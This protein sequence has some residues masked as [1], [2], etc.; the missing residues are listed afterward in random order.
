MLAAVGYELRELVREGRRNLVFRG[1][2]VADQRPVILKCLRAEATTTRELAR[3]RREFEILSRFDDDAVVRVIALE[4]IGGGLALVLEDFGGTTLRELIRG[5]G[6]DV[7]IFLRLAIR[8]ADAVALVH[9][10]GVIHKDVKPENILIEPQSGRVALADFSVSSLLAEES[11]G[12]SSPTVLEGTLHYMS[13]EQT[14]RMNRTVDYRT[15]Y[16]SLG[17]TYYQA[18]TGRLPFEG[19]DPMEIV[20]AHIAR[21]PLPPSVVAPRVPPVLGQ[22]ILRL[23]AK[24]AEAR[25][26]SM[27]GLRAD[28][29]RCL[30]EY[31]AKGTISEFTVGGHDVSERFQITEKLYGREENVR[32][33]LDAFDRV[34]RGTSEIMLLT[35][36][37]G[38]GKSAVIHEVHKPI[39]QRRG[40]F[41][42]GKFDQFNRD[43]PYASLI[44]ALKELVRQILTES[45]ANLARWRKE[46]GQA[47]GQNGQVAVDVL[48][49]LELILG[50]QA[51]VPSLPPT[52]SAN[53]FRSVFRALLQAMAQEHHPLVIFLDDLQWSDLATLKLIEL[54]VTDPESRFLLWIGAYRDNEVD[55]SHLVSQTVR[56]IEEAKVTITRQ[57]IG[58]LAIEHTLALCADT[59][60]PSRRD[61]TRFAELIQL[62]TEGNPFFIRT[63]LRSFY[64]Q[65]I[66]VFD[67][68]TCTWD[69]DEDRLHA[70][71]LS[72]DVVDLMTA[73]IATLGPQEGE[74]LKMAA[75]IGNRFALPLLARLVDRSPLEVSADLWAAVEKGLIRPLGDGYKY[76][77]N[78]GEL[79]ALD[80]VSARV[81]YQF[82]HDKIQQAAYSLFSEAESRKIHLQIGRLLLQRTGKGEVDDVIFAVV[83]HLNLAS[84]LVSDREE[85]LRLARLDLAA[86]RKAKLSIAYDAAV[87]YLRT[88]ISLLPADTW[89]AH[90]QLTF[91]LYRERIE[92]EHLAG[93]FE[94]A[95]SLF[96]P[97]LS[98]ARTDIERAEVYVI[99]ASLE[100]STKQNRQAIETAIAGLRLLGV[101]LPATGT[102]AGVLRELGKVQWNLRGRR[103]QELMDLPEIE[104]PQKVVALKLLIAI[105]PAAYF[106]DV[107]L[108]MV[109]LLNIAS[110]SLRYGLSNVSAFGF[111]GYGMVLAGALRRHD[112]AYDFGRLALQLNEHFRNP[113][114]DAKL[115]FMTGTFLS[116]WVRPLPEVHDQLQ[117]GLGR[118]LQ[119]G[120]LTYACYNGAYSMLIAF[121][122]GQALDRV[123]AEAVA[124]IP[125]MRRAGEA[126]GLQLSILLERVALCL[127]GETSDDT[128]LSSS[129]FD[130]QVF[131]GN[132]GDETTPATR[133]YHRLYKSLILYLFG[134]YHAMQPLLRALERSQELAFANP[135]YVDFYLLDA[136]AAAALRD[137]SGRIAER[138]LRRSIKALRRL[139]DL[140]P[141][142]FESRYLLALAEEA[143][144]HGRVGEALSTYNKAIQSARD[145]GARHIEALAL[146]RAGRF[147]IQ[148]RQRLSAG[149]Y[150]SGALTAYRRWGAVAKANALAV[151]F[152]ELLPPHVFVGA[153]APMTRMTLTSTAT[154]PSRA[155]DIGTVIKAS[156]AISSEIVLD[157]LL[158]RLVSIVMENAGARR[159]VLVLDKEGELSVEAEGTVEPETITVMHS[160]PLEEDEVPVAVINFVARSR[161][162]L[163]L[164]DATLDGGF[165]DDRYIADH[166]VR[167]L[168]C[169]PILHQGSLTGVLYLENNIISG[170]FTPDRLDLLRQLAAQVAIS[171][172][173]ARLYRNLDQAR[174]EAVAADRAK[175]RFLMS[176]SHELRTPLNAVIGYTELIEE[177]AE[178]GD[179]RAL[180]SDL[181]KIR[182]S[183]TRLLRTLTGIL[184]LSRLEAG[185]MEIDRATFDLA[186]LVDETLSEVSDQAREHRDRLTSL[187][188]P[189][190]FIVRTDRSML[191]YC[192]L[193]ILDNACRFTE[194]GEVRV[195][196]ESIEQNGSSWI[197]ITIADTGIGIHEAFVAKIFSSFTQL[198][199]APSRS[200][201]GTGVS[202]AVTQRFCAMMGG[203]IAVKSKVGEGTAFTILIP[204]THLS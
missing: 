76:I 183:A 94:E 109:I 52:E 46:L 3:L 184:E 66:I 21:I 138:R 137:E 188:P 201:E 65:K 112:A 97:L 58:A 192:L 47:L 149:F 18:L 128:S 2:R 173:N 9:Q 72:D 27:R 86:G 123:Q 16:Y 200:Y 68:Q 38:V 136:L 157:K 30:D 22:I 71:N 74:V 28:L 153:M 134:H 197:R 70:A 127:R 1:R 61:P 203:E 49:E 131:L 63:L 43:I 51:P 96:A 174:D 101:Q 55:A 79:V 178:E 56:T 199:D 140:C 156:Q 139:V 117:R 122:E 40:H 151:E 186:E 170:A 202:L 20:H 64:E 111:A 60:T 129:D 24:T 114:L 84:A 13:P 172:E 130:E 41:I 69:W 5:E 88:G 161:K 158:R 196:V 45:D 17:V 80:E 62:K 193:S 67:P 19:N 106:V 89:S 7:A 119:T 115:D 120:D 23:M 37:S 194:D 85:R 29:E 77:A 148:S 126:D 90:Y 113:E 177:E 100:T 167:S 163:V 54:I 168:L 31:E 175:T 108:V 82:L 36:P 99:K 4:R 132:L 118:G 159:C 44:Q 150:L 160:R 105:V 189:G 107:K 180:R 91:D 8:L 171:V 33:L 154:T 187:C 104:E 35:G 182:V 6:L 135:M 166:Q 164:D 39:V 143:R 25:Y 195:L 146:E 190:R 145:H 93:N 110:I 42:S 142:N 147:G 57:A 53:R 102:Y 116:S 133:F 32:R 152:R 34:S 12:A 98:N 11:Q 125:L 78:A 83:G 141:A 162:D 103:A 124:N 59:L 92:S 179:V 14:G 165:T 81:E 204:D 73:R 198:D 50:P 169:T 10:R 26:Q 191:H 155:L 144:T 176:M 181:N 75:C 121:V 185:K 87:T 15:D 95:M 48:P